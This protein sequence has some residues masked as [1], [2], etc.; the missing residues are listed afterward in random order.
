[1]SSFKSETYSC[2]VIIAPTFQQ[3]KQAFLFVSAGMYKVL[4]V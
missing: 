1:M 3:L 2:T 4:P